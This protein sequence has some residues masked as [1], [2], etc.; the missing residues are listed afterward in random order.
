MFGCEISGCEKEAKI[1]GLCVGHACNKAKIEN[2][3]SAPPPAEKKSSRESRNKSVGNAPCPKCGDTHRRRVK[4]YCAKC[5]KKKWARGQYKA[6]QKAS[7]PGKARIKRPYKKRN[8]EPLSLTLNAPLPKQTWQKVV[9]DDIIPAIENA[10]LCATPESSYQITIDFSAYPRLHTL[11]LN[12][13]LRE[14]R[15]PAMQLLYL[16]KDEL[17]G[18]EEKAKE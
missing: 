12:Q 18:L 16:I 6:N 9:E 4:G 1:G 7:A 17:S 3:V 15:P 5:Y 10:P 14:L 2:G 11:L 8:K 13:A